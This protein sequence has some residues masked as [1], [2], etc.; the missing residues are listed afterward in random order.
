SLDADDF[1]S[2]EVTFSAQD[3]AEVP[4]VI[5]YRDDDGN[6]YEESTPVTIRSG[7]QPVPEHD[8]GISPVVI[9]IAALCILLV[10]GAVLYS[11]KK[12]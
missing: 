9:G 5:R 8:G 3:T 7:F 11:R 1:S 10:A 4:L 6:L 2:F 12:R